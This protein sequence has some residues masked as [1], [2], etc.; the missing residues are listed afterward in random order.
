MILN[1]IDDLK[2][3]STQGERIYLG[4]EIIWENF[5]NEYQKL[6]YLESDGNAFIDTLLQARSTDGQRDFVKYIGCNDDNYSIAGYYEWMNFTGS[7]GYYKCYSN[8][9]STGYASTVQTS[10]TFHEFE[11]DKGKAKI[12]G[13]LIHDFGQSYIGVCDNIYLF[14]R[15]RNSSIND[16]GG[17][18]R[19]GYFE[20][21]QYDSGNNYTAISK[22]YPSYRKSDNVKGFYDT[23]RQQFFVNAGSGDFILP[24]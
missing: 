21:G 15:N 12:D 13:N 7:S 9:Y 6:Q 24:T 14:G 4:N 23:V 22:M 20:Y 8:G 16:N 3:G 5:P 1:N 10:L 2:V 17:T 19:I 18:C 11:F